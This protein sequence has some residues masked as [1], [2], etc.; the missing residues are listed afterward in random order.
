M[1]T[2]YRITA[3]TRDEL[4]SESGGTCAICGQKFESSVLGLSHIIP[5]SA[6]GTSD[7]HNLIVTCPNCNRAFHTAPREIEFTRFLKAVLERHSGISEVKSE[8]T[9]GRDERFR[10]DLTAKRRQHGREEF[11]LIE[12]S[13]P[14]ALAAAPIT[15]ALNRLIT[16]RNLLGHGRMV[17]AVPATLLAQDIAALTVAGVEIWDL[18]YLIQAF[19]RQARDVSPSYFRT[20]LLTQQTLKF[21]TSRERQ[22]INDL[23]TCRA[24][25][26]DWRLYQSI[27]GEILEYLLTPALDKP[28][29]EL[30]DMPR[31]NRRDFILPNYAKE[32]FWASM[33]DMY[34][35]DYVVIDAKNSGK[36]LRKSDVL[37]VAH[38]LKPRGVGLF[39]II[40]CRHGADEAG[41]RLSLRE[42]WQ[43]HEKLILILNDDDI[44]AMLVA[45]FE[46]REPEDLIK[47]KIQQFRLSI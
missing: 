12:C 36:R 39:G 8:V 17:L 23:R 1:A 32:G 45:R 38:Y 14:Q 41:C 16:Y 26:E 9:L 3:R 24:G 33:R 6:G 15:T 43:E 25:K 27:V 47:L 37:Q 34:K 46:G 29:C 44:E 42:E 2:R 19:S 10:A 13:T 4:F 35:A 21:Q 18:P 28:I 31:A 30:S 40:I 11:L 22:L 7:K 5:L 20:L